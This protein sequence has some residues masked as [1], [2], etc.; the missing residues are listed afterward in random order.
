MLVYVW[1]TGFPGKPNLRLVCPRF[2]GECCHGEHLRAGPGRAGLCCSHKA[3]VNPTESFGAGMVFR[4][5]ATWGE[6][7]RPYTLS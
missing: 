7:T 4:V 6:G 1:W 5:T 3:S 2:T